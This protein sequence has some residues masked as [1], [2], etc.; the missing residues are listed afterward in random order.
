MHEAIGDRVDVWTTL[1][2]PWCAAFLGYTG[3]Q[4]APGRQSRE[5]GLAAAHHLM[6]GHGLAVRAL[7]AADPAV[8]V[9]ITLNLYAMSAAAPGPA[10]ADALR[11]IDGLANRLFLDPLLR[12]RYP[13]DVL[14]DLAAIS[15]F[16]HVRDG[17]LRVISTPAAFLAV[18]YY[19]RYVVTA[20]TGD[21]RPTSW[22]APSC[23]PGSEHVRF[24]G[25]GAPV[26]AMGWEIDA[27][28]LT[29]TLLRLHRDHPA[30][31]LYISENG[32]AFDDVVG[33]DGEV[34]DA[35]RV[36]YLRAHLRACHDA[37][38]TG[39]PLRGYFAWSL[40]D[41]FEWAQGYRKRFGLVRVDFPT[42][43]RIPKASARW[44]ARVI[45]RNGLDAD[46][47]E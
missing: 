19:S 3:G 31:P 21:P 38:A 37:I 6:L 8:E 17:D 16:A 30:L 45:R 22:R 25:Q 18:N 15:D 5:D 4:H 13:P 41:N 24:V 33:P 28:G 44:Y 14:A 7:R 12:G 34:E 26:T 27:P 29:E 2:E 46:H 20:A 23:W 40:L 9:G 35:D 43:Q 47:A 32:A 1:N 39:V 36:A 42:Q 11:R 10:D